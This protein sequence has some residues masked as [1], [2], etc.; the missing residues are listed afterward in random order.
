MLGGYSLAGL[1]ALWCGYVS[2]SFDAVAGVS[3]SVWFPGWLDFALQ[4]KPKT[5]AVYLSLGDRE[6][7]TRHPVLSQ[8]GI[9]I[10]KQHELLTDVHHIPATLEWNQ[11]NH[12][13]EPQERLF[14]GFMWCIRQVT[15]NEI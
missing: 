3:P 5:G 6:E 10:R 12:F 8:V 9:A 11:G 13:R 7:K 4:K 1:F 14:K 15:S 2:H